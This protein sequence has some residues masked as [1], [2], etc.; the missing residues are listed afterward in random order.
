MGEMKDDDANDNCPKKLIYFNPIKCDKFSPLTKVTDYQFNITAQNMPDLYTMWMRRMEQ[1]FVS[2]T[3][4]TKTGPRW[5]DQI[6]MIVTSPVGHRF[7]NLSIN[8]ISTDVLDIANVFNS[9]HD[10]K[11]HTIIGLYEEYGFQRKFKMEMFEKS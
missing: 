9:D 7:M 11:H 2:F 8:G 6:N 10:V 5:E 3:T 4:G 1:L